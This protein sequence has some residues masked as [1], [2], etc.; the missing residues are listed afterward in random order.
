MI[1]TMTRLFFLI[2]GLLLVTPGGNVFSQEPAPTS[3]PVSAACAVPHDLIEDAPR[4]PDLARRFRAKLPVTIVVIGG[5][6]TAGT[7]AGEGETNAYPKRLEEALRQRH[8][9]VPITVIN[10][11][12]P[13]QTAQD[14]AAR[15]PDDVLSHDPNLVIWE[16]GTVDA[17]RGTDV[18]DFADAI[19]S[20]ASLLRRH[21]A[22]IMLVDMQF[23]P[24]TSSIIDFDP[25]LDAMRQTADLDEIY[26]FRR[27]DIMHYW[28]DQ[29]SFDLVDVPRGKQAGLAE[30][31]YRCLGER[32]A[33]AVDYA[34]R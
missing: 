30:E 5:A 25:Y 16:T 2:V 11:G 28:S 27:Y 26:L 8:P 9:G 13:R 19:E 24:R 1:G 10:K 12:I 20:G 29:G 21:K 14:M 31:I 7:A 4:Y 22:E 3:A 18:Q 32:M 33:D 17:V 23:N 15:F 6:S 34:I